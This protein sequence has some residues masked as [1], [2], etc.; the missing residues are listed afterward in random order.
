M[1]TPRQRLLTALK[2]GTP[3]RVPLVMPGFDFATRDELESH[4]DPY[5]R[6]IARRV[7]DQTTYRV[8]VPSYI[9]RY[10]VTPPQRI[11]TETRDLAKG[12]QETRGFIDTPRG[13]L[14]FI[15]QRDPVSDT[16]WTVEYP[17]KTMDDVD[18]I[19][20]IPWELPA[21][22]SPPDH[23][24][25]DDFTERGVLSTSISSPFVCVAGM[26]KFEQFLE[27][28][29]TEPA[30][31]QKLT[32]ICLQRTLDILQVL[33]S[34]PGIEYVWIGGSEWVTPP[35]ASPL[36]YDVLVQ[37]QE[38]A[39]ITYAHE[40]GDAITHIHCHGHVRHALQ[41]TIERSGDYTE[42]VEPP[43]DGDISM[44]EAKSLAEGCITLGGN[45]ECRVLA[46]ETEE[47]V[48][49]A[50]YAAFS[51]GKQRFVLRPTEGP[52]PRMSVQEFRNWMKMV[53]LWEKLSVICK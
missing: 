30:L 26:M 41:R 32:S 23:H 3:D 39:L 37:E 48:E 9:N 53:D 25:P 44:M 50:V 17:V 5:R 20:S 35:M 45:I 24:L 11:H 42:P 6:E 19:S 52:S 40:Q 51:G 2:G 49:K 36:V 1:M 27:L 12:F 21:H 13:N 38:R 18:K 31:I 33:F 43:P 4:Y 15:T 28:T 47:E 34:K 10:L 22:L 7:I 16:T 46:N 14:T 29:L 8:Q